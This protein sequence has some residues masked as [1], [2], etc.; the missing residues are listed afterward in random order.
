MVGHA[1]RA[2]A[3]TG[4]SQQT[5]EQTKVARPQSLICLRFPAFNLFPPEPRLPVTITSVTAATLAATKAAPVVVTTPAALATAAVTSSTLASSTLAA[6]QACGAPLGDICVVPVLFRSHGRSVHV[7]REGA[8]RQTQISP[9]PKITERSSVR[10]SAALR[11][12][13]N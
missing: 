5:H 3:P 13:C 10:Y 4:R 11:P 8:D 12:Q 9:T 1:G 2:R 7:G 6:S